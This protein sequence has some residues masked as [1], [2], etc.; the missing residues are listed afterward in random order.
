MSTDTPDGSDPTRCLSVHW[1]LPV[2]CVL[3]ATHRENWHEARHPQTGTRIRYR[4]PITATEELRDGAWHPLAIPKPPNR[5]VERELLFVDGPLDGQIAWKPRALWPVGTYYPDPQG[6]NCGVWV[7]HAVPNDRARGRY[8]P[9]PDRP[10]WVEPLWMVWV[11]GALPE[12]AWIPEPFDPGDYCG[13]CGIALS[14]HGADCKV[15]D[16]L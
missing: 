14:R 10:C 2:Q 5:A 8:V 12:P 16:L 3:A 7:G 1:A 4:W 13:T 6:R 15:G 9:N 11:E